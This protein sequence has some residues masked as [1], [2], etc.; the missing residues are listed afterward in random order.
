MVEMREAKRLYLVFAPRV[1]LAIDPYRT[2]M[3]IAT[4]ELKGELDDVYRSL[5]DLLVLNNLRSWW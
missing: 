4:R 2:L 1:L 3:Y 5:W